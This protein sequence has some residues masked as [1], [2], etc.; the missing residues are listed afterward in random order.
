MHEWMNEWINKLAL[1]NLCVYI[2]KLGREDS[3]MQ[4]MTLRCKHMS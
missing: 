2:A 1:G 4:E 3:G